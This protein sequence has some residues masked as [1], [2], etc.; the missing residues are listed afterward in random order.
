[1]RFGAAFHAVFAAVD[2]VPA[3]ELLAPLRI[4][5]RCSAE[6]FRDLTFTGNVQI[7]EL[8]THVGHAAD[9]RD[10]QFEACFIAS[11][12]IADQLAVPFTVSD[13]SA[14][15]RVSICERG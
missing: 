10:A 9:P 6:P 8:S 14:L 15:P 12:I 7:E 2:L 1:M 11:E 3:L 4:K 5:M 13:F